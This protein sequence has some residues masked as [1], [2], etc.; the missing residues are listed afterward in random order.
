[1]EA[2]G[3]VRMRLL[4]QRCV[5]KIPGISITAKHV[6]NKIKRLKDKYSAAYDMLNTSGF[7]WNDANQCVTVDTPEI[8]EEYLKVSI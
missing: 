5:K 1:M 7:G 3:Q 8:L 4:S 2:L 6:Q